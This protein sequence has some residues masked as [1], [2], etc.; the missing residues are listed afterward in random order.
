MYTVIVWQL[1]EASS[2]NNGFPYVGVI[3]EAQ[4]K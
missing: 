1:G 3:L 4:T 2:A